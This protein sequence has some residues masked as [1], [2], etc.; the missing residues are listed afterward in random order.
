MVPL[1]EVDAPAPYLPRRPDEQWKDIQRPAGHAEGG[2]GDILR[3]PSAPRDG[4]IRQA[5]R[6]RAILLAPHRS[7]V[8]RGSGCAAKLPVSMQKRR[9]VA[10]MTVGVG[11][12]AAQIILPR[13]KFLAPDPLLSRAR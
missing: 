5:E 4:D 1:G 3:A 2:V 12:L 10:S 8:A 11:L 9:A 13:A 6:R 7:E